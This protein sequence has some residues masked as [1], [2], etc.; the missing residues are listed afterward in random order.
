MTTRPPDTAD[1]L[2]ALE[3]QW[4]KDAAAWQYGIGENQNTRLLTQCADELEAALALSREP[5]PDCEW[6]PEDPDSDTYTTSCKEEF[7]AYE[8]C[9][10]DFVKF[11]CYCGRTVKHV[12]GLHG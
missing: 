6:M 9:S 3:E 5:T 10:L 12:G 4:R 2:R 11:C 8:G 7:V 1:A